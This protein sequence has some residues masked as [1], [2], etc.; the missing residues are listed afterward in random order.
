MK[1][2]SDTNYVISH[3]DDESHTV[4]HINRLRKWNGDPKSLQQTEVPTTEPGT[5]IPPIVTTDAE[6]IANNNPNENINT[7]NTNDELTRSEETITAPETT[8]GDDAN[9]PTNNATETDKS[10]DTVETEQ[11]AAPKRKRGR[12]RKGQEPTKPVPPPPTHTHQLRRSIR[13]PN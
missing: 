3:V 1:K 11:Q 10:K 8:S 13:L 4:V 9:K 7:T 12:P 6:I 2:L 5:T